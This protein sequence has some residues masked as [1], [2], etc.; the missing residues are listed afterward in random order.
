M[1]PVRG[2]NERTQSVPHRRQAGVAVGPGG[3]EPELDAGRDGTGLRC[4]V[5]ARARR[6]GE[7][8]VV[9]EI[10]RGLG[11]GGADR[12]RF[13]VEPHGV[14][15][16][17]AG[18]V[19]EVHLEEHRRAGGNLD[20]QRSAGPVVGG[21]DE[22]G[23]GIVPGIE[24]VRDRARSRSIFEAAVTGGERAVWLPRRGILRAIVGRVEGHVVRHRSERQGP[25][26]DADRLRVRGLEVV[27]VGDLFA[28]ADEDLGRVDL[29]SGTQAGR[30]A[31]VPG[32]AVAGVET[33]AEDR[34]AAGRRG[35]RFGKL[36]HQ[37]DDGQP[38]QGSRAHWEYLR[39][40]ITPTA[41]LTPAR[42]APRPADARRP[43]RFPG[44][45]PP[46]GW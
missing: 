34:D 10:A 3:E 33:V 14:R 18:R 25:A 40:N 39:C 7:A 23:E 5:A 13:G 8:G 26:L 32:A 38:P 42:S 15:D 29:E 17:G 20:R 4:G 9:G 31:Q 24:P 2:L 43:A 30:R 21:Q 19:D 45:R 41:N 11:I 37:R 28:R 46:G 44:A 27:A 16:R 6:D 12:Q 22:L 1:L 36:D 35:R